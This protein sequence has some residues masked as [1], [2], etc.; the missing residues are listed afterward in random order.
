[1]TA[2]ARKK[3][4]PAVKATAAKPSPASAAKERKAAKTIPA[5]AARDSV[6]ASVPK[7]RG[8]TGDKASASVQLAFQEPADVAAETAAPAAPAATPVEPP[9]FVNG[10]RV[11]GYETLLSPKSYT[12]GPLA[13]QRAPMTK[14]HLVLLVDGSKVD[15]CT[16]CEFTGTLNEVITHV[17]NVDHT[18]VE[19]EPEAGA[20]EDVI[21]LAEDMP[22]KKT[23][24]NVP[25]QVLMLTIGQAIQFGLNTE[26]WQ[27]DRARLEAK[28]QAEQERRITAEREVKRLTAELGR[29]GGI[30]NRAAGV[31]GKA[32]TKVEE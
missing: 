22:Q 8:N 9:R 3:A 11:L 26:A 15:G 31:A 7:P 32:D 1:M 16:G 6:T 30:L 10:V 13:G 28:L 23:G 21:P 4:Q 25:S 14:R 20:G 27:R 24:T 5:K 18:E 19:P 2:P 17:R 29:I 12:R